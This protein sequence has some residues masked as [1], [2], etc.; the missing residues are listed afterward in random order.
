VRTTDA[1]ANFSFVTP[2]HVD[3]HAAAWDVRTL[4]VGTT[5]ASIARRISARAGRP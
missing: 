5:A 1:G 4:L 3:L 2:P